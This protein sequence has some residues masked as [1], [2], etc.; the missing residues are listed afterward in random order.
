MGVKLE[1]WTRGGGEGGGDG[2][3]I[4]DG[5]EGEGAVTKGVEDGPINKRDSL[6]SKEGPGGGQTVTEGVAD[7]SV[8]MRVKL[9]LNFSVAGA[10]HSLERASFEK[11][12][13]RDLSNASGLAPGGFC[14]HKVCI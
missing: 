11:T 6:E 5:E 13:V 3:Q 8:D 4:G 1:G 14:V 10:P 2:L 7:G 9:G 12:L